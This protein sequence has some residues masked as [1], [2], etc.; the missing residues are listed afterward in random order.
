M[1][2]EFQG[3][4]S[5][6]HTLAIE[7]LIAPLPVADREAVRSIARSGRKLD[8]NNPNLKT[9][10]HD[11]EFLCV[12]EKNFYQELLRA[13]PKAKNWNKSLTWLLAWRN[14]Y[15]HSDFD[16]PF[17]SDPNEPNPNQTTLLEC[18]DRI[19]KLVVHFDRVVGDNLTAL[20]KRPTW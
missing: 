15:A 16:K 13:E 6:V 1:V 20:T 9:I 17:V 7:H 11:F 18:R 2:A 4:C 10:N 5:D 8:V 3:Y 19:N 14:V 12:T